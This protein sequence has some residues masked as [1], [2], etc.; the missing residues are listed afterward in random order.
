MRKVFR[1]CIYSLAI[2]CLLMSCNKDKEET[3]KEAIPPE[4]LPVVMVH[5]F[6]AS[7]DTYEQQMLRF[8]SN[9]YPLDLLYTYEWNSL[10]V[11]GDSQADLEKFINEVL[12]K[13]GK[14]QV[15]LVGHSAG[16]NLVY[17]FCSTNWRAEKVRS[18][19]LL[20]GF[21]QPGPAGTE[22]IKIPTLNIF[23][24]Y[25]KI[26]AS[27]GPIAGAKNLNLS[28]KDHYQVATCTETFEAMFQFFTGSKPAT[29]EIIAQE[30]PTISGKVLSFGENLSGVGAALQVFEVSPA[31]GLRLRSTPDFALTVNEKNEWGPIQ[32]KTGAFYEFRVTT[33]K[34]GDR[35]VHYY[36]EPFKRD[37]KN[38][39]I[40]S[41]PP[42]GSLASLFLT[43][44]PMDDG[45]AVH[46]F[47]GASQAV[48]S[49][50]DE[51]R[52]NNI[53]LAN[54]KFAAAANTTI[55]LFMYD[56]NNDQAT[57]ETAISAFSL[58]PFLAGVDIYFPATEGAGSRFEYNGRV[59]NVRNWP[60][61]TEGVS[62]A[63][64]D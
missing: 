10:D 23:S 11:G 42:S 61:A 19:V 40:R 26:V 20:A 27:S 38:V 24:P 16:S 55:A 50:R 47:F 35:P 9:G 60:S 12:V 51:L 14:T 21:V 58:F 36:R 43:S 33:G 25:D 54:D 49:G 48:I 15:D 17:K 39:V 59:L 64:F 63:V 56:A 46:A 37:N 62:V 18:V 2:C 34:A 6:L 31:T 52:V 1:F 13:T 57:D 28:L 4:K 5:G 32:I 29:M 3:G 53:S 8:A 41:F 22:K 45:Q 44:L 7:G 30:N